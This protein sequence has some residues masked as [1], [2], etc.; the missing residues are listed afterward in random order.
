MIAAG[1]DHFYLYPICCALTL[2]V[3][4]SVALSEFPDIEVEVY[5]AA[6]QFAEVGAGIGIFPR[7]FPFFCFLFCLAMSI[8]LGSRSLG[9]H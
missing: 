2:A 1:K 6:T 3:R 7:E 9:N 4:S 5:E 8:S